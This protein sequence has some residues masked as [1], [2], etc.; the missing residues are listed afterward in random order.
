MAI[1][2]QDTFTEAST[3][4]IDSHTPDTGTGW[5]IEIDG[6]AD[7]PTAS[8]PDDALRVTSG[9][10][11]DKT[12]IT[13]RPNPTSAEYDVQ[14][15]LTV[16]PS[17]A[18][19]PSWLVARY[20][21]TSNYYVA[22]SNGAANAADKKI[23]KNV[24]GTKTE[25]AS[26]DSADTVGDVF[27]FEVRNA[28]KKLY[29]N[30]VELLST[31]DNAL[32]SAGSAGVAW[33][34]VGT[35]ATDDVSGLTRIDDYSVN[36][37]SSGA[38]TANGVT[39]TATA[40]LVAGTATGTATAAASTPTATASLVAGTATGAASAAAATPTATASLVAGAATG[41]ATAAA[42]TPTATAS[43]VAG[44]ATGTAA[45]TG[46]T[47]AITASLIAG[48]ASSGTNA[49]ASGSTVTATASLVAG[50]ATG[51]A[52]AS[53]ATVTTTA[54]LVAGSASGE[55]AAN[56]TANGA[57][58]TLTA[59][60]VAGTATATS[61]A[62]VK[63]GG[64]AQADHR[65]SKRTQD[66]RSAIERLIARFK[67]AQAALEDE[68]EATPPPVKTAITAARRAPEGDLLAPF[69]AALAV[70]WDA[71]VADM[72]RRDADMQAITARAL[73][74]LEAIE[75]AQDE[76]DEEVMLLLAA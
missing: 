31:S 66:P 49:T 24:A 1:I 12:I 63:R 75:Q 50:T 47:I 15:T 67:A 3:T 37:V 51:D 8:G 29:R 52:S 54:S 20:V 44:T 25:L 42:S 68:P 65:R 9:T 26:G 28:T 64:L 13:S 76:D 60:M 36:E 74:V 34:N 48:T 39:V 62:T 58:I 7:L 16:L 40:S 53:G 56:G 18:D 57:T 70:E 6:G 32:T 22:G 59:S 19:N 17:D 73:E 11:S 43:L 45:A 27:K 41:A 21:D 71:V 61:G 30:G 69:A 35:V 14:F 46:A 55:A 2:F 4:A 23:V 33:G 72:A 38:A 10:N 5:V